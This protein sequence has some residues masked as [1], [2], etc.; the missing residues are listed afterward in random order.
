MSLY[1]SFIEKIALPVGDFIF[2][3]NYLQTMKTW[4]RY[5]TLSAG[6]LLEIQQRS[7]EKILKYCIENVPFYKDITFDDSLTTV[8]NLHRFPILT[9]VI[10]RGNSD[11]LL[12]EKYLK[13]E[14]KKNFSSGSSGV[15]SF[16]YSE[17]KNSF[18]LQGISSHWY[19]WGGY[20]FGDPILQFGIS[21]NRTLP[22]KLKDLFYRVNYQSAF[23]LSDEDFARIY[24]DVTARET[25]HIIG[26]PSAINE[27]AE[28][29]IR[30]NQSIK[31]SSIVSLG[32][33]LFKH[34]EKNFKVAFSDPSIIDTYG[35]AEGFLIACRFDVPYY[36]I[37]S[38]HVFVE[39]VDDDGN[40]VEDGEMGNVLITCFSNLAQPFI[41]YKLGDL[42]K[43][44]PKEKYP[45]ARAFKYPL[46]EK[47]IGRE[48]DI[49]KTSN[50]KTL[51]V[52]SFTGILEYYPDI[53][54]Y[55][56]IQHEIESITIEYRTDELIPLQEKTLAE[57]EQKIDI[58][59]ESTL[60]IHFQKVDIIPNSPSGKPQ[61]IRSTLLENKL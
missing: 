45:S 41:R 33:K 12:S 42:G 55:H 5:D 37:S 9:K 1:S 36:Y 56:I 14:L 51:I 17:K 21:P 59:S 23:S 13:R 57:I 22:K 47:I 34:F 26:Y 31:I 20:K 46:L 2:G 53:L 24:R 7:L 35:C 4:D 25:R 29:L 44:L 15:Q 40:P 3:G 16:S 11:Q 38:P 32:D 50:G 54:Q 18:Y 19:K 10:L 43:M 49:I 30:N 58:L 52:H 39:I 8:E 48:T 6:E 61:I 60:K 27:F 28:Y